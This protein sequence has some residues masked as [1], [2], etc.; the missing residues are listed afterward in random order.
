MP[1]AQCDPEVG[2]QV[3]EDSKIGKGTSLVGQWWRIHIAMLDAG[4]PGLGSWDPRCCEPLLLSPFT[5]EP[6]EMVFSRQSV[7]WLGEIKT[8]TENTN[9]P[10]NCMKSNLIR[11]IT[12]WRQRQRAWQM[13]KEFPYHMIG[14]S[15][16]P[17]PAPKSTVGRYTVNA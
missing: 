5:R 2:T 15:C 3:W 8:A 6:F 12:D 4:Y 14:D 13:Q 16:V 1:S 9:M 7:L 10:N 17:H 11:V